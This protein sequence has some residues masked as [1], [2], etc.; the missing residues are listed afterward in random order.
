MRDRSCRCHCHCP[1]KP[2]QPELKLTFLLPLSLLFMLPRLSPLLRNLHP[3]PLLSSRSPSMARVL[4]RP[5]P[6]PLNPAPKTITSIRV[7]AQSGFLINTNSL[8]VSPSLKSSLSGRGFASLCREDGRGLRPLGRVWASQR[9]YRK[10]RRRPSKSKEKELEL[11]VSICIEE[12]L[13]DDAEILVF[14]SLYYLRIMYRWKPSNFKAFRFITEC[15]SVCA[16][17]LKFT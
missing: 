16:P 13:P 12:D 1:T 7:S 3:P 5:T 2:K 14:T 4:S 11:N 8:H 9:E 15:V 17:V 10:V 6:L